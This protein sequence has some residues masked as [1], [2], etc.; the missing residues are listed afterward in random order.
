VLRLLERFEEPWLGGRDSNPDTVVQ[1]HVSYRWT[2]SQYGREPLSRNSNYIGR[3]A[4][5]AS[6]DPR[7]T[8]S[9]THA[10]TVT[11]SPETRDPA[12]AARER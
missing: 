4:R 10:L 12:R 2:T 3:L 9:A 7:R 5:T 6:N 8:S 11:L 1:S